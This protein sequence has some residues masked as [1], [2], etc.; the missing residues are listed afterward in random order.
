MFEIARFLR[1]TSGNIA[2]AA[3]VI[4]PV[5]LG[6]VGL[7]IDYTVFLNQRSRMQ[8]AADGAA[9]AALKEATIS[10]WSVEKAKAI[11]KDFVATAMETGEHTSALY[12]TAVAYQPREQSIA[13]KIRQDGHGYFVMGLFRQNPQ[14][15][16]VAK[17]KTTSG[18][19]VCLLV[20]HPSNGAA[21]KI[22]KPA[23][24]DARECGV[25]VNSS[26][27]AALE[28]E[29]SA[30]LAA[31]S[32][33]VT[34]GYTGTASSFASKPLTDC[35]E[36]A[37]PIFTK[38]MSGGGKCDRTGTDIKSDT[39]L[40]PGVYCGGIKI[41]GGATV[42]LRPG[43]YIIRDGEFTIE[44]AS[45]L[46][47]ENAGI[48]IT[49]QTAKI[50]FSPLSRIAMTAPTTGPMAGILFFEDPKSPEGRVFEMLSSDAEVLEGLI[51]L[52]RGSLLVRGKQRVGTA[53]NW[54]A[55]IAREVRVEDGA[56]MRLNADFDRSKVPLPSSLGSERIHLYH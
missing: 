16:V 45:T 14:I 3:A 26:D 52:P 39:I 55:I 27:P 33:C 36:M 1:C 8:E 7:A 12:K 9:L 18:S 43:R 6:V 37:D 15:E 32:V 53:S 35:P 5:L 2:I 28:I 25:Q 38:A 42:R 47:G 41:S 44:D 56:T 21:L 49:G 10:G 40:Y 48:V 46:I 23:V 50:A 51:Y 17:A 13:V 19:T 20:L 34:G 4:T 31:L 24:V 54:T 30:K 11:V 29:Q 22:T